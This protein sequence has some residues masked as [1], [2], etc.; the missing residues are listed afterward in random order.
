[1]VKYRHAQTQLLT[2]LLTNYIYNF[3]LS[4][5]INNL[6]VN[7]KLRA[8][9]HFFAIKITSSE[10]LCDTKGGIASGFVHSTH[11]TSHFNSN[12]SSS[13]VHHNQQKVSSQWWF[14]RPDREACSLSFHA[15]CLHLLPVHCVLLHVILCASLLPVQAHCARPRLMRCCCWWD[16]KTKLPFW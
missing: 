3:S 16:G 10:K 1:M 11:Q 9:T 14:I 8:I 6:L 13:P 15:T 7:C 2:L 12:F 4:D 5:D